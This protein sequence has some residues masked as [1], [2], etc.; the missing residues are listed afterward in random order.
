MAFH[1]PNCL[2]RACKNKPRNGAEEA[3]PGTAGTGRTTLE[4][5]TQALTADGGPIKIYSEPVTVIVAN[6][7]R[8]RVAHWILLK[9]QGKSKA[10][11]AK[12]MGIQVSTL[13][14]L[15]NRAVK[16][17]WLVVESPEEILEH[18]VGP[19]VTEN[20][21]HFLK[22]KD[23]QVTIEAAKGLGYFKSHQAVKVDGDVQQTNLQLNIQINAPEGT[24]RAGGNAVGIPKLPV[25]EVTPIEDKK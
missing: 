14:T 5:T 1:K 18:A 2:C 20:L 11:A 8:S 25:I 15:I 9:S 21:V 16:A 6:D 22:A 17:G 13:N 23:K 7:A 10:E 19:L 3:E 12:E 4:P 24:P